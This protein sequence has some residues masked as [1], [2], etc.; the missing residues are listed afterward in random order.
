MNCGKL[1]TVIFLLNIT[2]FL[3]ML[4][5]NLTRKSLVIYYINYDVTVKTLL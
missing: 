4:P 2:T 1:S 3:F 5:R